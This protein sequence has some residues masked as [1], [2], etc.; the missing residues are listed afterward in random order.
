M[1]ELQYEQIKDNMKSKW[2]MGMENG[3]PVAGKVVDTISPQYP[4]QNMS[5]KVTLIEN[6]EGWLDEGQYIEFDWKKWAYI[7]NE[8]NKIL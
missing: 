2:I 7:L 4:G 1:D 8:W 3:K 5:H 6:Y